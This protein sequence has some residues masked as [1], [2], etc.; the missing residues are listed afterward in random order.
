MMHP[1]G[2]VIIQPI[3]QPGCITPT[4]I[5]FQDDM[6]LT[7]QGRGFCF[8]PQISV[9]IFVILK[10]GSNSGGENHQGIK[11]PVSDRL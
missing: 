8:G 6:G 3:R 11:K 9:S 7:G 10:W 1:D 2:F 5:P 4:I